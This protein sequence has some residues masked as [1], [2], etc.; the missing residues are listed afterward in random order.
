MMH[1]ALVQ[2]D[3]QVNPLGDCLLGKTGQCTRHV[4]M[5]AD[6]VCTDVLMRY[7]AHANSSDIVLALMVMITMETVKQFSTAEIM[8]LTHYHAI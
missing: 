2:V 5:K 6:E 4:N 3:V 8:K 1:F 7:Q